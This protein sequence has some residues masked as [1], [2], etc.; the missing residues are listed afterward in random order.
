[1]LGFVS[2]I[3]RITATIGSAIAWLSL[4][5]MFAICAVVVLRYG[6][7]IGFIALQESITY[8]HGALFMLA[9]GFTLQRDAHVRVDI[10]YRQFNRR[11]KAWVNSLGALFFLLPVCVFTLG[12][13]W[14]F[15][16]QSWQIKESSAEP[17]G[18]PAVYLLKLLIP[19]MATGLMLQ[20]I[21]ELLRNLGILMRLPQA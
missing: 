18:I 9:A 5:M 14:D 8:L 19:L 3:D 1:M 4:G 17:G 11:Q 15:F 20:G 6:L 12:I 2:A 10:F 13:S 7:H 21:A 16:F